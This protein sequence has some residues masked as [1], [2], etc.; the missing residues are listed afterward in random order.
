MWLKA[1]DQLRAVI[2]FSKKS[3]DN[4]HKAEAKYFGFDHGA[5]GGALFSLWD[6]PKVF[7]K[8]L[9]FIITFLHRLK[10]SP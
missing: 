9:L 2:D 8:R 5:L 6:L 1:P 10:I 4:W 3:D 7:F